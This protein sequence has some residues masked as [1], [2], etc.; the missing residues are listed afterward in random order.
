MTASY[1]QEPIPPSATERFSE[2][3][4]TDTTFEWARPHD[5]FG[6]LACVDMWVH[7]HH[8]D[9]RVGQE[10]RPRETTPLNPEQRYCTLTA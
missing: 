9:R 7:T 1:G 3:D 4:G 10:F 2:G 8:R 5:G 6:E